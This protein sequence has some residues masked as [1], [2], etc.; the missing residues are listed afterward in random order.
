[1]SILA[2]K[3]DIYNKCSAILLYSMANP[4]IVA[5]IKSQLAAGVV[6]PEIQKALVGAG[7]SS[8]DVSAAFIEAKAPTPA[9]VVAP[10]P[11]PAP[12]MQPITPQPISTTTMQM[13]VQGESRR[14]WGLIISVV[15]VLLL[16]GGA[17]AAYMFVPAVKDVVGYYLGT[18]EPIEPVAEVPAV[19]P[20]ENT[21]INV[22]YGFSLRY[23][24]DMQQ[25]TNT[26]MA[27]QDTV[28]ALMPL[29]GTYESATLSAQATTSAA[30]LAKCAIASSSPSVFLGAVNFAHATSS[31]TGLGQSRE[32]ETYKTMHDGACITL[33]VDTSGTAFGH[34][35]PAQQAVFTAERQARG[36]KMSLILQSLVLS[37]STNTM[38]STTVSQ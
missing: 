8:G 12:V 27:P 31:D 17:A 25:A 22:Q 26:S 38:A 6:E 7:W 36:A 14:S 19:V 21:Y 11:K 34:L 13:N 28:F 35:D 29:V 2:L 37:G 9:P 4:Q 16:V 10:T 18:A 24:L 15:A 1:M 23:P 20:T 30:A 3:A 5:Y 32:W 33:R